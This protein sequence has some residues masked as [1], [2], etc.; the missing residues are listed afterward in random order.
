MHIVFMQV[1]MSSQY[2]CTLYYTDCV[3][4]HVQLINGGGPTEGW[5]KVC[6]NNTY[7]AVCDDFWDALDAKV[8]CRQLGF[9]NG[10]KY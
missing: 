9:N 3:N 10:S 1:Y 5:V 2:V 4:G 8:V 6:Y 7:G